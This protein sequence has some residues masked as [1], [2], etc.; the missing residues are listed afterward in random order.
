MAEELRV[1]HFELSAK[2]GENIEDLFFHII[3]RLQDNKP[4]TTESSMKQ[5][6]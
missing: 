6:K 2:T 3:D 1:T 5:I 4:A